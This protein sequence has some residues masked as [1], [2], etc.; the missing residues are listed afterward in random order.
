MIV[1]YDYL[2]L[3]IGIKSIIRCLNDFDWGR[4]N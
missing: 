4:V 2:Q 3:S 1:H